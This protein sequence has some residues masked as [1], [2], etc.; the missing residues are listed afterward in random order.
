[1][2]LKY[3]QGKKPQYQLGIGEFI[4]YIVVVGF[5]CWA[6]ATSI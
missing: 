6:I 2:K 5:I 1:M 3:E 4:F